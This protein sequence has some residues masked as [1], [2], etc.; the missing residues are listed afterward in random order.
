M[1]QSVQFCFVT[2]EVSFCQ[3]RSRASLYLFK[4]QKHLELLLSLAFIPCSLLLLVSSFQYVLAMCIFFLII[5]KVCIFLNCIYIYIYIYLVTYIKCGAQ[6][7]DSEI[8]S[9]IVL[10]QSW[11]GALERLRFIQMLSF[12]TLY[13]T[14]TALFLQAVFINFLL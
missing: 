13:N 8:K 3:Q 7:Q 9:P 4:C 2:K 10:C 14:F 12:I 1:Q 6:I 11:P 5:W